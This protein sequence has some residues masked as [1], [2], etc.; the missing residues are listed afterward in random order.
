MLKRAIFAVVE[1]ELGEGE[2]TM[3]VVMER[4]IS[5]FGDAHGL[6]GLLKHLDDS[7]WC[8]VFKVLWNGL[9]EANPR[10]PFAL[11]RTSKTSWLA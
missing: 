8:E 1:R 2:E 10:E 5:H 11:L 9:S 3:A 6:E 4:Q 7:P